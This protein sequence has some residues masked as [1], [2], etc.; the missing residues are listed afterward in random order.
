MHVPNLLLNMQIYRSLVKAIDFSV[1]Y[2]II[3]IGK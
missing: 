1:Y 2:A 3:V